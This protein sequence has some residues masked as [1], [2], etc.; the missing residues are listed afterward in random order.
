MTDAGVIVRRAVPDDAAAVGRVLRASYRTLYR[1]WY[2]DELLA[3]V[4]PEMAR[5]Q[6]SLLAGGRYRVALIRGEIVACGGWT[7]AAPGGRRV[8]PRLGHVRHFAAHPDHLRKGVASAI[9]RDCIDEARAT[10]VRRLRCM[11]SLPAEPFYGAN[12]FRTLGFEALPMAG[13]QFGVVRME[14]EL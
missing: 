13:G 7:E 1:G 3:R 14:R 8:E 2:A 5:P 9:L 6:P 10:G 11:S 12:G 4:L